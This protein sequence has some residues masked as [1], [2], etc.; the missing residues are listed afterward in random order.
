MA[1]PTGQH[2]TGRRCHCRTILSPAIA[3]IPTVNAMSFRCMIP[4][5][6]I[7]MSIYLKFNSYHSDFLQVYSMLPCF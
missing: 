5:L 7:Y 2:L 3:P 1:T 6:V 4:S